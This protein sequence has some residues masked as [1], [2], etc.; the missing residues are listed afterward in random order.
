M[1]KRKTI[2][3][4]LLGFGKLGSGFYKIWQE[5]KEKIHA[6]TGFNLVLKKILIKNPQFKRPGG[7]DK[8][9][10]TTQLDDILNDK[11][12][13]IA[14]DAIGDIEPTFQII[15]KIIQKKI[16]II[17]AN[18]ILLASKMHQLADL[19][20]EYG[21]HFLTE[22]AIGGGI[23]VSVILQRDLLACKITQVYGIVSGISNFILNEMSEKNISL[24]QVLQY[25]HIKQIGE[26]TSVIDYEGAHA[27]MKVSILAATAFGMD[28]NHLRIHSEGIKD[29]S[30]EDIRWAQQFGYE[31]KILAILQD[32]ENHFDIRVHPVLIPKNHPLVSVKGEYSA[33]YITTD[34][35]GQFL[36][37]G[38]GVGIAPASN[39][40]LRDLVDIGNRIYHNPRRPSYKFN[41]NNKTITQI[42]EIQSA[43]YLRFTCLDKP[44]V[45]GQLTT[46]VGSMNINIES[47]HAEQYSKDLVDYGI[48]HIFLTKT[49]EKRVLAALEKIKQ[50]DL[51]I[52]KIKLLRIIDHA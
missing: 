49:Y 30:L 24:K 34:L 15:K 25:S 48:V 3:F 19:S 16:H 43:Y 12:I 5:K 21:I 20:N 13:K 31:I 26:S 11:E 50:L 47:A 36:I 51:G 42:E 1:P 41:W 4:A 8:A 40:I 29:I 44:G 10:F 22:P 39:L 52:D 46:L 2:S 45:M 27:A 32:D 18:R 7:I 17:S 9:L 35:I 6:Q 14:I 23:P 38:H 28:V 33:Y 37:Y